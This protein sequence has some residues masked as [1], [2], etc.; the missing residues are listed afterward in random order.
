MK[1]NL[2]IF[3]LIIAT[4]FAMSSCKKDQLVDVNGILSGKIIDAST[5]QGLSGVKITF[6]GL[7]IKDSTKSDGTFKVSG[8]PAGDYWMVFTKSGYLVQKTWVEVPISGAASTSSKVADLPVIVGDIDILPLTGKAK[9][10]VYDEAGLP[11]PSV[12]VHVTV[13]NSSDSI[14]VTTTDASGL[15]HFDAL[16]FGPGYYVSAMA[17]NGAASGSNSDQYALTASGKTLSLKI[18]VNSA[19][20]TFLTANY[21][22]TIGNINFDPTSSIILTYSENINASLTAQMGNI[23]L[24]RGSNSIG[25]SISAANNQLTIKPMAN[26]QAGTTYYLSGTVYASTYKSCSINDGSS[27]TTKATTASP[28]TLDVTTAPVIAI[29]GTTNNAIKLT[30]PTTGATTY[31]I[32]GS[33][34]TTSDF[35]LLSTS[36]F[37]VDYTI[38]VSAGSPSVNYNVSGARFYIV[39]VGVDANNNNIVGT[40]S[41]II[42]KP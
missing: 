41:A 4:V 18:N 20:I 29:S 40:Q 9:G 5:L 42:T 1:K 11:I 28:T 32:Y 23:Q 31:R 17:I 36:T 39:P 21:D 25:I 22:N 2:L 15:F 33:A 6:Q 26:L 3:S 8:V 13:G 35:V 19:P 24:L 38:P 7:S 14:F 10:V 34:S 16:P 27:F 37:A 30:A 12:Q